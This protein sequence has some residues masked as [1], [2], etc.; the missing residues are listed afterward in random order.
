M[1]HSYG[2]SNRGVQCKRL[3]QGSFDELYS[4]LL[5]LIPAGREL[6]QVQTKLEEACFFA[7]R[8]MSLARCNQEMFDT[9]KQSPRSDGQAPVTSASYTCVCQGSQDVPDR[10]NCF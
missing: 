8:G 6:S 1:F 10:C 5:N 9:S 3:I 7:V 4:V 2:L